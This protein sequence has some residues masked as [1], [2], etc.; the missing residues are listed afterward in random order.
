MMGVGHHACNYDCCVLYTIGDRV[1]DVMNHRHDNN[2]YPILS[3]PSPLH[4][5]PLHLPCCCCIKWVIIS[6]QSCVARAC[7]LA[8]LRISSCISSFH[9]GNSSNNRGKL[10]YVVVIGGGCC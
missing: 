8:F 7:A 10:V 3:T 5:F 2:K 9:L 6:F 1:C 4:D